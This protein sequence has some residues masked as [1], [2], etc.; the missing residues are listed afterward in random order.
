M[1]PC[2]DMPY[3]IGIVLKIYPSHGQQRIVAV[4]AGAERAVY[5]L[6]VAS[7]NE[8]YRLSKTA[9]YVPSDR[10]RI[11]YIRSKIS[12][13]AA[14]K[15]TLPFLYE[16]DV[17][18]QTVANAIQH[19]RAAW[20]HMRE[21]HAGVPTFHRKGAEQVWNTNSHYRSDASGLPDGTVRFDDIHH[22]RLPKL[23]RIRCDGSPKLM[24][25]LLSHTGQ[26]RIGTVTIRK[27]AVGE[28]WV[29]LQVSSEE[30][31]Y[32]PFAKTGSMIGIDLNLMTLVNS[33]DGSVTANPKFRS[34][35]EHRLR[36]AQRKL[37]RRAEHAK[38]DGRRLYESR[39][40]QKARAGLACLHRKAARQRDDF[41]N[42]TS[43]DLVKNHDLVAAEDLKVRNML[44]AHTLAKAVSDAGWRMLLTQLQQKA[45]MY[46][47][48]VI[49]VPPH[50][51]T[52]TCSACGYVMK[53]EEHLTLAD[54]EWSCPRCGTHHDRDTNAGRNILAKGLKILNKAP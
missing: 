29:S 50:N 18:C 30:P 16:K 39:N 6:L 28:Y 32:L 26:T 38:A 42:C 23:G 5:N 15:N 4:N 3:H 49:L 43:R 51:T 37:S 44:K 31:F 22:I 7:G 17:D 2:K 33:S 47:K 54:R 53:G 20:K 19:Y 11:D 41:L 25:M 8:I 27:D 52:Q 10:E 40:Y 36:K 34:H 9:A 48:T 35:M 24:R 14:I 46:G 13:H 21:N 45:D 1:R 12:S